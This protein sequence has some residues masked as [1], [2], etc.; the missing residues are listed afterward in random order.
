MP[1]KGNKHVS[2]NSPSGKYRKGCVFKGGSFSRNKPLD[3][4]NFCPT[5]LFFILNADLIMVFETT[6]SSN[7]VRDAINAL[8][9][10]PIPLLQRF[11]MKGVGSRRMIVLEASPGLSPY[12]NPEHYPTYSSIE[13][14]PNG[15]LVH[16]NQGLKNYTWAIPYFALAVFRT[17]ALTIHSKG[18]FIRYQQIVPAHH[19]F[20][21]KMMQNKAHWIAAQ[22]PEMP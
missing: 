8:V 18:E 22:A 5:G 11:R 2:Q 9:G 19:A 1:F 20:I 13:I 3:F 17:E 10:K 16:I 15:I 12:L 14:R 21:R 4:T 6:F 7:K